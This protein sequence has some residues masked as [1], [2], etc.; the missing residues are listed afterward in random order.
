MPPPLEMTKYAIHFRNLI[1]VLDL[2]R[3]W[4]NVHDKEHDI[5]PIVHLIVGKLY[6]K[7][8][9]LS[10]SHFHPCRYCRLD[11]AACHKAAH[12]AQHCHAAKLTIEDVFHEK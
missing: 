5:F 1:S 12:R 6:D 4:H 2:I 11:V 7:Q 10:S 8:P 9:H 3:P